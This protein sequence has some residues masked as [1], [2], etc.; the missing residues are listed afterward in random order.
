MGLVL[1]RDHDLDL[2]RSIHVGRSAAD[3]GFAARLG[4]TFHPV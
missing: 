3:R 1:A 4:M 2:A